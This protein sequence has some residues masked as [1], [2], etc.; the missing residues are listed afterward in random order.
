MGS[1]GKHTIWALV[2]IAL[3]SGASSKAEDRFELG[4]GDVVVFVGGTNMLHLQQAG[5][6]EAM[7]THEFAAARPRF[8]DLSWEA[9]TVFHQGT[10]IER[11]RE[12]GHG[13]LDGL[14]NLE[15]QL[16]RL[17]ATVVIA[18]FGRL[19]SLAGVEG[20]E[21]FIEAYQQLIDTFQK[22]S[23]R[24]VLVTP[25]PFEKPPTALI[26]D[27]S[28]R[29]ADLNRYVTAIASIAA[30]REL[31]CI[32]L[33]THAEPGLTDNGMHI[34]PASQAYVARE[35]IRQLGLRRS[36]DTDLAFLRQAVI[37]KHRLWYDYWRPSNWKLLYG[38]DAERQ[39]TRGGRDHIAFKEEWKQ[40]LP[41]ISK[42]EQRV[43]QIAQGGKDPGHGRPEPE[44]LHGDPGADVQRELASFS[45]S[46]DLQVNLFAS[47]REGLT[48]PLA[49]RWDPAGRMY[50]TVST[51][52]PHVFPGS[53]PNDK[54][55]LLEDTDGDGRADKSH[56]FADGL[57]IPTGL[58]WG[59][60]GVYVGQNTE[61]LF[62]RDTD[63]DGKADTRRVVLGGF[64][65]GDSHQTI[66][67]FIWSP[68]GELFFGHGDGCESRV[69]TPWGA[70][71]LFN[72]GFYR[73]RP[74]R[75]HLIPFLESHMGPGNPWGIAFDAWGQI[76]NV[77]GAGGVRW[78]S[79]ALVSTTHVRRFRQ[80]GE[81]GGYCGIGYLDGGHLPD[82]MHGDFVVGDYKANR[83]KRFSLREQGS[84]YSL[85]WKEPL[86]RSRHRNFR[87][88][89]VKVGPDGAV[90]VVDWYNPI[91]CH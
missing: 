39:F 66:N 85:Q 76:L 53:L 16:R 43:W 75:L 71:N 8:R 19:E 2:G 21:E 83:V 22:Q 91:T 90:K 7:L 62:L 58:E 84:G 68:G 87:P 56:V 4:R 67:S 72:A 70:S 57:N 30:Q 28:Q 47:E 46:D 27:L 61:L 41:L 26:P 3:L 55:L 24:V 59:D 37:E 86:L 36:D 31:L 17:G 33:F 74:R 89:D 51:T 64:G 25:T 45:T 6:V 63:G 80:I 14:G 18:Q 35:I 1:L 29:N 12:D 79:P 10:V 60:G 40:L 49:V 5:Y 77:D 15:E 54:I 81:E 34:R 9:D 73:F 13:D 11:W 23:R 38:D 48:S 82:S 42:A 69:E 20:L 88:I 50:V 65:N 44:V 32:D 52:Y 78:L